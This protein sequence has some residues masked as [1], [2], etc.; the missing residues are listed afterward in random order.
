MVL[1][2]LPPAASTFLP[3]SKNFLKRENYTLTQTPL[4]GITALEGLG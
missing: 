3:Y 1:P 2:P 4:W